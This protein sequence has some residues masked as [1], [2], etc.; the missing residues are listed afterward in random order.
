MKKVRLS[1]VRRAEAFLIRLIGLMG[2]TMWPRGYVGLWFPR[3]R[4]VHT[5]FTFLRPDLL[6]LGKNN[7]ILTIFPAAGSWRVFIGPSGTKSCLELPRG[8][9]KRLGLK[10]GDSI[11]LKF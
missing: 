10:K 1:R 11:H 4:S 2:R 3:C 8:T 6:F 9:V 7:K 5:F